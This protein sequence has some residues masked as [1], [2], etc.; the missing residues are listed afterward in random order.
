[1]KIAFVVQRY[2]KNIE[3]GC[4]NHCRQIAERLA[5][6]YSVEVLTTCADDYRSWDNFYPAGVE[7]LN[8]V[9]V[10]RF[11]VSAPR[12]LPSFNAAYDFLVNYR[13]QRSLTGTQ[14]LM[15]KT[16]FQVLSDNSLGKSYRVKAFFRYYQQ[17]HHRYIFQQAQREWMMRQG[18][19]SPS[20]LEFLQENHKTYAAVFFFSY[21]YATTY[22]GMPL[23]KNKA[24]LIPTVHQDYCLAFPIFSQIFSQPRFLMFKTAAEQATTI[25][26]YPFVA[27]KPSLIAGV[28]VDGQHVSQ[29]LKQD[30]R[31]EIGS[32][33]IL[34]VGRI[35]PAKGCREL[36]SYFLKYKRENP[37]PLKLVLAGRAYMEIPQHPDIRHLGY[38]DEARKFAALQGA[39]A[40]VL[41]SYFESLSMV[42]LEAFSVKT[43]ILVNG[44]CQVLRSHCEGSKGGLCYYDEFSF[45]E[46]LRALIDN[47]Q[48]RQ[49]MGTQG[50]DYVQTHYHWPTIIQQYRS[51]IERLS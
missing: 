30:L 16:F 33:Y 27:K 38:I 44:H 41:P 32:P 45:N 31:L 25:Q 11:P 42:V 20:L 34:Y 9:L 28:G 12:H 15:E 13:Y 47:N 40:L 50:K 7:E 39:Q 21:N 18:P 29:E 4:E 46:Q 49:K 3:G 17:R 35:D 14:P 24:I 10:R 26:Q 23:V 43:P 2:G 22:Y 48:M 51:L 1:M 36:F 8:Q 5:P 19:L 6:Y 37:D